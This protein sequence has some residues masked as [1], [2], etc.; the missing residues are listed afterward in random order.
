MQFTR[1]KTPLSSRASALLRED[2]LHFPLVTGTTPYLSS[3]RKNVSVP[4]FIFV[5]IDKYGIGFSAL[6]GV[7][8]LAREALQH[9][10]FWSSIVGV[11]MIRVARSNA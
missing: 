8:A 3:R 7:A 5:L 9:P 10:V 11:A 2:W 6:A 4:L 1:P